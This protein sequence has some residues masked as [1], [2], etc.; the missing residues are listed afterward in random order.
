METVSSARSVG[1]PFSR[2]FRP[3][4]P[5]EPRLLN[6]LEFD[7]FGLGLG[8]NAFWRPIIASRGLRRLRRGPKTIL[9]L[10]TDFG[11][12]DDSIERGFPSRRHIFDERNFGENR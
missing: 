11:R 3:E 4:F 2:V 8:S 7:G 9:S 10:L 5:R 12:F 1:R 6:N